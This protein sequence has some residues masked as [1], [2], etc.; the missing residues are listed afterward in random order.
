MDA[1]NWIISGGA[2]GLL[3]VG[4]SFWV[5]N[6]IMGIEKKM[7][8]LEMDIKSNR[9]MLDNRLSKVLYDFQDGVNG[10]RDA[11]SEMRELV[12]VVKTQH[13]EQIHHIQAQLSECKKCLDETGK[14]IGDQSN[15]ITAIETKIKTRRA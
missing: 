14:E 15:R 2:T 1:L 10:I 4:F 11:V 5:K 9:D 7:G 12:A 6:W 8:S 13:G 3:L